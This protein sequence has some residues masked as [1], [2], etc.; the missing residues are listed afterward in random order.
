M[1]RDFYEGLGSLCYSIVK[2]DDSIGYEELDTLGRSL[3][4]A[5]GSWVMDTYGMRALAKLEIHIQ[6][7][8]PYK[9]A[10]AEAFQIFRKEPEIFLQNREKI[11]E[12]L[13]DVVNSD[14]QLS[15]TEIEMIEL[16]AKDAMQF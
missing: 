6:N 3:L 2:A 5:F 16:F 13:Q 7:N 9:D 11:I 1:T 10:Y 4:H 15:N 12:I 8:T 14:Q